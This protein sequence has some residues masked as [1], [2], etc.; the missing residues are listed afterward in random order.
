MQDISA[1]KFTRKKN[2]KPNNSHFKSILLT[3][4]WGK[5]QDKNASNVLESNTFISI[6]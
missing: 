2:Q 3:F 1:C 6:E 4:D 5:N